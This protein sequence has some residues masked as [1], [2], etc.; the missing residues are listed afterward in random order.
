[1]SPREDQIKL[2]RFAFRTLGGMVKWTAIVLVLLIAAG[3][4]AGVVEATRST[5]SPV[6]PTTV[7]GR[8]SG[9]FVRSGCVSCGM[10]LPKIA[11]GDVYCGWANNH[12]IV[13]V[14]MR[15][16]S[17]E[18]ATV[19]W[20][21]TYSIVNGASHGTGLSS[22]QETKLK[23]GQTQSV[24]VEQSPKGVTAGTRLARCYP[25]FHLISS[26]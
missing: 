7:T 24:F 9:T 15:N 22:L 21:P 19:T 10:L 5:S 1:V 3:I 18:T 14:T 6:K 25:S 12:V 2:I 8:V 13:H 17:A 4:V 26:G 11:T 23:P 20:H 16:T